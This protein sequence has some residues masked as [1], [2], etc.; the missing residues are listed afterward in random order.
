MF[1]TSD[2]FPLSDFQRKYNEHL[3]RL[4]RTGR[5]ELLTRNGRAVLVVQAPEAYQA[6]LDRVDEAETTV[7]LHR[8]LQEA[9]RGEGAEIGERLPELRERLGIG[10]RVR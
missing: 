9:E 2:V 8:A 7:A 4:E 1:R 3:A 10:S 5:P 6:L